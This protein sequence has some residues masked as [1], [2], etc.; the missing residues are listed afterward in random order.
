MSYLTLFG[1]ER[2]LV[3]VLWIEAPLMELNQKASQGWEM[4]LETAFG[5]SGRGE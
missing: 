5:L 2:R 4:R 1:L 3:A